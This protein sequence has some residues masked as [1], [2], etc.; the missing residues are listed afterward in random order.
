MVRAAPGRHGAAPSLL[1]VGDNVVDR[2]VEAGY[3]YPGGNAVNVAVHA[4]RNGA[5]SAY[6]GAVGTDRAGQVVLAALEEEGVDTTL[7]RQVDGP[8]AYADVRVV[9]GNRVFGGAD[10]GISRFSLGREDL[11]A[12]AAFDIVHTG[13]CS[14]VEEQLQDLADAARVLS[15]DFSERP[16]DYVQTHAPKVA[17]AIWSMPGGDRAAAEDRAACLRQLG[18]SVVAITMGAGGAVLLRDAAIAY[19]P[20]APGAVVDTLGAGDAFI[21]RLL[22]GL[23]SAEALDPLVRN[24]TRYATASCSSYGAFGHRTP[25]HGHEAEIHPIRNGRLDLR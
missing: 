1:A 15:F 18:P 23:A 25:L 19:S 20:V 16:W 3:M 8:N 4:R 21:A 12:A 14:M 13:E 11:T 9:D 24:A 2:Y 7:T 10:V 6:L 5:T 17:V 22:V